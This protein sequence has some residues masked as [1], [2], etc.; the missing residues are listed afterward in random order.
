V[1]HF[2]L[3][4]DAISLIL[5]MDIGPVKSVR[6]ERDIVL[7]FMI[8]KYGIT[9]SSQVMQIVDLHVINARWPAPLLLH[10]ENRATDVPRTAKNMIALF[11]MC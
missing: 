11:D 10:K 7:A 3:D 1:S 9:T 4:S 6:D 5:E 2:S 8:M